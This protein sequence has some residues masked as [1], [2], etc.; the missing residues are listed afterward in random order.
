LFFIIRI[1]YNFAIDFYKKDKHDIKMVVYFEFPIRCYGCNSLIDTYR[2]EFESRI[3]ELGVNNV[4]IVLDEMGI[5]AIC[6]R[7]HF[8]NPTLIFL[9]GEKYDKISMNDKA[10]SYYE[11]TEERVVYDQTDIVFPTVP[12]VPTFNPQ[13]FNKKTTRHLLNKRDVSIEIQPGRTYLAQ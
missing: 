3:S 2:D 13:L 10:S 9:N 1:F 5:T 11:E 12:G 8:M 7:N 4:G 6:C